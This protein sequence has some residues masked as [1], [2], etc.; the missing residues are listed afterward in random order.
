MESN[1][2]D[3]RENTRQELLT[4]GHFDSEVQHS[5]V[6]AKLPDSMKD[7]SLDKNTSLK[8]TEDTIISSSSPDKV[9][10]D[11]PNNMYEKEKIII[12]N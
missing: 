8:P 11:K 2:T 6:T 7:S 1:K 12:E 3:Q 4:L 10:D 5:I 9:I